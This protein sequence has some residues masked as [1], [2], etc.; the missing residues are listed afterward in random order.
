MSD[1]IES[2]LHALMGELGIAAADTAPSGDVAFAELDLD[3]L[4]VM[5]LCVALEERY[6]LVVEPADVVKQATLRNLARFIATRR[7]E[8]A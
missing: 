4:T 3:S 7:P 2:E 5:D 1:K 6:D 8:R